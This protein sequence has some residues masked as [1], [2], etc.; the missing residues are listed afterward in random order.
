[1]KFSKK[2]GTLED[3]PCPEVVQMYNKYMGAVDRNDQMCSY[4]TVGIQT[5]KWPP[6]I[7]FLLE[8]SIV[9]AFICKLESTNHN[10]CTQLEFHADLILK[11]VENYNGRKDQGRPRLIPLSQ[12]LLRGTS[13]NMYPIMK[14]DKRRSECA[15]CKAAGQVK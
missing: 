10:P 1:M 7:L 11:L 15:V 3:V 5:K 13:H 6:R 4:F 2:D 14:K 12:D 9:N 8:R